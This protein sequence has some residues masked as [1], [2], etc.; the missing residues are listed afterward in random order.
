MAVN[1]MEPQAPA[2]KLPKSHAP[3]AM[4]IQERYEK[5]YDFN[6]NIGL[7]D[8]VKVNEDF[9]I[10]NQWIGVEANGLPTP[11][12]NIL[13]Q[14]VNF[15]VSTITSE[16][17]VIQASPL[18]SVSGMQVKKLER[19]T[20]ILNRQFA[21]IMEYN[22][23]VTKM[24]ELLRNAAVD[25]DGCMYFYFDP[26]IE[27]NQLVKGEIVAEIIQNTRVH[28]GNPNCREVQLQP[29]IM[30][31]IRRTVDDV[32]HLAKEYREVG[33]TEIEDPDS[34]KPDSEKF[35][36]KYD[37][38]TDDK[39]TVL[40]YFYKNRDTGTIWC[41]DVV[42]KGILR[43]PYDTM[44]K[45][46]PFIW[47]SWDFIQ[48]CYHGQAMVTGLLPNQK[49]INKM[50]AMVQISL[51]TT[52]FPKIV[53]DRTRIRGWDGSVGTAVGVNGNVSDVAKVLEGA[54]MNPQIAQ[55]IDLSMDKTKLATVFKSSNSSLFR[56]LAEVEVSRSEEPNQAVVFLC[57]AIWA[58]ASRMAAV[59]P[60]S[61]PSIARPRLIMSLVTV[62]FQVSKSGPPFFCFQVLVFSSKPLI[63]SMAAM[64]ALYGVLASRMVI[65]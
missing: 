56:I 3:T 22:K 5:A 6:Q 19:F 46:Y 53:Y 37:S 54:T 59:S 17:M 20:K 27:N 51:M 33:C 50:F 7:Y 55:F 61:I 57:R 9:F 25:G 38:Y 10:G 23:I 29:W 65:F 62:F 1:V 2:L 42:D 12:Y 47:M 39:V 4:E 31:S 30:T 52:A 49:F 41:M 28:F 44:C 43:K 11:T 48:D 24:R 63:P 60:S 35:D 14:V 16:N 32:R 34:I 13:K 64:V 36:N 8:T 58:I 21:A 40:R 18:A 15:Q 45:L 26:T